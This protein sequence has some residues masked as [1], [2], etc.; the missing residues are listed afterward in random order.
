[1]EKLFL[2]D[3]ALRN[4]GLSGSIKKT[5]NCS[6]PITTLASSGSKFLNY[7]LNTAEPFP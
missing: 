6:F 1:M 4:R 3:C 5:P 2:I 7:D